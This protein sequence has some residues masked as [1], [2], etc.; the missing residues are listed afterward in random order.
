MKMEDVVSSKTTSER[1]IESEDVC[2]RWKEYCEDLYEKI[3]HFN[4]HDKELCIGKQKSI[5]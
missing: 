3:K 5:W 2:Q 4:V 1:N